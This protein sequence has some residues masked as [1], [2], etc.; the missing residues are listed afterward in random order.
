MTDEQSLSNA[1]GLS[2]D[3][4]MLCVGEVAEQLNRDL[5]QA[6][7]LT[8]GW[9]DADQTYA[10]VQSAMRKCLD[11]LAETECWGEANRLPSSVLWRTAKHWLEVG[12]LQLRARAKPRGYAG[13]FQM[14]EKICTGY[15]CDHPLGNAFDRFFQSQVAPQ[16]V[17]NRTALIADATVR[18]ARERVATPIHVASIG[19]GPAIDV[20]RAL[21]QLTATERHNVR[22]TLMDMD[23]A[24]LDH[25]RGRLE[26]LLDEG[27]LHCVRENLFRMAQRNKTGGQFETFDFLVCSGLF[28]YLDDQAFVAM[29]SEFWKLLS[30]GGEMMVF[31]FGPANTSRD[32]MEW[33]GNWYLIYRDAHTMMDLAMQARLGANTVTVAAEDTGANLYW[34]ARKSS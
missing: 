27:Q 29:L 8:N 2:E 20:E 13:D 5:Q 15:L 17:R 16:A 1:D 18:F 26:P 33:I 11:R 32:Y 12:S 25:A 21:Q 6:E 31:N 9:R 3:A 28:D 22:V 7:E 19:S 24:A 34:Q 10:L 4:L 30:P 14:L 23:P